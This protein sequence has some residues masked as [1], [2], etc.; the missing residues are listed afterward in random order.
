MTPRGGGLSPMEGGYQAWPK[1]HVKSVVFDDQ[2]RYVRN[3]IMVSKS[4]KIKK[5]GIFF[6]RMIYAFRV[7]KK[8]AY[9]LRVTEYQN[10]H[11]KRGIVKS[12]C[13]GFSWLFGNHD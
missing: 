12:L 8:S 13:E 2:P 6:T 1:N 5:K 7:I 10:V 9:V 3:V 4:P 11:G